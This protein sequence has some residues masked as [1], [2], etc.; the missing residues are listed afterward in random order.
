[1]ETSTLSD[2]ARIYANMK[3]LESHF[4]NYQMNHRPDEGGIMCKY[5]GGSI[6]SYTEECEQ[7]TKHT[8]ESARQ[9]I[10]GAKLLLSKL[11]E[12]SQEEREKV[13]GFLNQCLQHHYM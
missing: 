8:Q 13:L 11:S 2:F 4:L 9:N 3:Y 6:I 10:E 1:M 7:G 5:C 12:M